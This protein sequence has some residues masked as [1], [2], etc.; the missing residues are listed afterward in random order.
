MRKLGTQDRRLDGI[1]P[2]VPPLDLM[3]I[4]DPAAV[5]GS[6]DEQLAAFAKAYEELE[7]RI[8]CFVAL[9]IDSLGK[10]ALRTELQK[11]GQM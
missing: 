10:D 7:A 11:I 9:P 5:I 4:F 2:A 1:Q 3:T 8:R 6:F